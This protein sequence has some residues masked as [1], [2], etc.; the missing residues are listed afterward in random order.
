M[1]I[2]KEKIKRLAGLGR[3]KLTEKEAEKFKK[4]AEEIVAFF[5]KLKEAEVE[6]TDS[7]ISSNGSEAIPDE[8]KESIGTGEEKNNFMEK[9]NGYL[10]VPKVF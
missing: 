1:E 10:K 7:D 8:K 3:I 9:E 2:D 5:D 4:D 6:E